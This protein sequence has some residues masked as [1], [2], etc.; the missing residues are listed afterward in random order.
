MEEYE[1]LAAGR[2]WMLLK[3]RTAEARREEEKQ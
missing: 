2:D 1:T 3:A